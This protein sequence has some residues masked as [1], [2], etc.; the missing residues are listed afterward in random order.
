MIKLINFLG[1][2]V[3][4]DRHGD[5][6]ID[7]FTFLPLNWLVTGVGLYVGLRLILGLTFGSWFVLDKTERAAVEVFGKYSHEVGPGGLYFKIPIISTVRKVPTEIRH[8]WELGFRTTKDNDY[9]EVPEEATMLTKGGHLG[10]IYWIFQYTIND[11]YTYLYTVNDPVAVL[12]KLGQG[13]MRL[14]SG[15]TLLDDFLTTEKIEIQEKNKKLLQEYCDKIGLNITINEVKLQDCGLPNKEV[16]AAYDDVMNAEKDRDAMIQKAQG[17][18]NDTVP[19]ARGQAARI[20]NEAN[21]YYTR[22]VNGATGEIALFMGVFEEYRQNP[23]TTERK[24]WYEAM[25]EVLSD[26]KITV[27]ENQGVLNLNHIRK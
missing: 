11:V 16:Q 2:E 5:W 17:Y 12:D 3:S 6:D 22:Q 19:K 27:I 20:L 15:Q 25:Q 14:V 9:I 23:L 24:L 21:S 18:H 1:F 7:S 8:R 13:S 10:S 4:K 26:A